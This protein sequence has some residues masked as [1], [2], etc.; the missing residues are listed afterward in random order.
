M[1]PF[2]YDTIEKEVGRNS[3]R[4]I[5]IPLSII[6]NLNPNFSIRPYQ[7]NAFQHF[8]AFEQEEFEG[9]PNSP[10]HLLFNMATGSGKTLMMA[11][12]ILYLY[13]KGYRNFLFF[14]N[15]SNIIQKTKDNFLNNLSSKFLFNQ[16]I[17]FDN[18]EV[19]LKEVKNFEDADNENINI[20]FTTIQLLHTSLTNTK[21]GALTIEDFKDKKIVLMAD[22][23]HHLNTSTRSQINIEGTWEGTVMSI[24]EQNRENYLLEFTATM[25]FESR[26][27][28]EK[29]ADKVIFKY[30]LA[31]FRK[32]GYSKDIDLIRSYFGEN[33]RMLQAILLSQYRQELATKNVINLKPVIL[34]KAKKTIAESEQ[35]KEKFH[36]LIENLNPEM[37]ERLVNDSTLEIIKKANLFFDENGISYTTLT[38]RIQSN[39]KPEN[40][41]SANSDNEAEANQIKLNTLEDDNNPIRAVFAVQKLN[42]GWDVLNLFDIVRLYEDRDGADAKGRLGKTTLSEAQLIGR[43]ARYFPFSLNGEDKYTRKFDKDLSNEL[44]ILEELYYHTK[45]DSRYISEIT[46]A[47]VESGIYEDDKDMVM[48]EL[49]LKESFKNTDFYKK[50]VVFLNEKVVKNYQSVYSLSDLGVSQKN[51]IYTL[52]SGVGKKTD[53]FGVLEQ[54]MDVLGNKIVKVND[55]PLHVVRYAL[56]TNHFFY[57]NSIKKYF[58]KLSS[59]IEFC[60]QEEYLGGLAIEFRGTEKRRNNLSNQDYLDGLKSLLVIIEEQM[61]ANISIYEGTTHFKPHPLR[62]TFEDKTLRVSKYE[63]RAKGQENL[64]NDKDWYAYNANFGTI[65]EKNF[66]EMFSKRFES[67]SVKFDD[68]YLIRN[69]R[70]IKIYDKIG[71]AFEPDFLLFAK[72]KEGDNL[73]MQ[74]F[75]EPKGKHL[76]KEDKWKEDF[77]HQLREDK[78]TIEFNTDH[79]LIT[80]LPFYNTLQE[81]EFIR[82]MESILE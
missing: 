39:F 7:K 51:I 2:L 82:N 24:L 70:S 14:V 47:L 44:K 36:K 22:E 11:G 38:S 55:I 12:L 77:L 60:E 68:M 66:V 9:K 4:K 23:A 72:Q 17:F 79:Y 19:I 57:F 61:K 20:C 69:E 63:E 26:E 6:D 48:K 80:G 37:I 75:I 65:E 53:V 56:T 45:E 28:T 30:D 81:N 76:A 29:Y 8:M 35:N 54:E 52:S 64:V 25:D 18:K 34:F 49:K 71:R 13:E 58:P 73:T 5:N 67:W 59:S 1:K 50:G 32:D 3:I 41:I 78:K 40:C 31:Q 27:I 43:G 16:G 15:S 10:Y 21:E 46:R 42:E 33:E 74:V 62:T